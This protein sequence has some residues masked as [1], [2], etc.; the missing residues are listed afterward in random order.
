MARGISVPIVRR[1][2]AGTTIGICVTATRSASEVDQHVRRLVARVG[3]RD[4]RVE[5]RVGGA[6]REVA[7][8][9]RARVRPL[10]LLDRV[11]STVAIGIAGRSVGPG[12]RL[13]IEAPGLFPGVVGPSRSV[14]SSVGGRPGD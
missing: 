4:A 8:H 14:S 1:E 11:R 13:R 12:G 10:G 6:F 2:R 7:R 5:E 3:D 9:E